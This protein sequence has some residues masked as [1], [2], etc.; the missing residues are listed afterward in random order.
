[1]VSEISSR[2]SF[3]VMAIAGDIQKAHLISADDLIDLTAV[4]SPDVEHQPSFSPDNGIASSSN[5][6]GPILC[7]HQNMSQRFTDNFVQNSGETKDEDPDDFS[8]YDDQSEFYSV[9]DSDEGRLTPSQNEQSPTHGYN[10]IG[11]MESN[12]RAESTNPFYTNEEY[13]EY[14]SIAKYSKARTIENKNNSFAQFSQSFDSATNWEPIN[15]QE[16]VDCQFDATPNVQYTEDSNA[17]LQEQSNNPIFRETPAKRPSG[18]EQD[19]IDLNT[20]KFQDK[21]ANISS[22]SWNNANEAAKSSI[23]KSMETGGSRFSIDLESVK[24]D[25]SREN[26]PSDIASGSSVDYCDELE[27]RIK[28]LREMQLRN[29][30]KRDKDSTFS[31]RLNFRHSM[32]KPGENV[33]SNF[34]RPGSKEHSR[35][36]SGPYSP[37][38]PTVPTKREASAFASKPMAIPGSQASRLSAP[39][40]MLARS[41]AVTSAFLPQS[42]NIGGFGK[43]NL[44]S[45]FPPPPPP[46]ANSYGGFGNNGFG[47]SGAP[48]APAYELVSSTQLKVYSILL[49]LVFQTR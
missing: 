30:I 21:S 42:P 27:E 16:T 23:A 2:R 8:V 34:S 4:R 37:T 20:L 48:T 14:S 35:E 19:L 40:H 49:T 10:S 43:S 45:S 26:T 5:P 28:K 33:S 38:V 15:V 46:M 9:I 11:R 7:D 13:D 31:P 32:P 6:F 24:L 47:I 3:F 22:I 39:P 29:S 44:S 1:M 17:T 25:Q 36:N 12:R 41:P 18:F